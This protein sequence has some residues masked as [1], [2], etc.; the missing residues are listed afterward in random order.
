MVRIINGP[1]IK[2]G[3]VLKRFRLKGAM[4]G[5][6]KNLH[7]SPLLTKAHKTEKTEDK[8]FIQKKIEKAQNQIRRPMSFTKMA[9][10]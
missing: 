3:T 8:A 10:L 5:P 9:K 4:F 1:I 2:S 7:A 6:K